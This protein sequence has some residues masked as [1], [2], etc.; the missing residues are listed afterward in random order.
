MST[1]R[2]TPKQRRSTAYHEA[3]HALLAHFFKLP[4]DYVTILPG[5]DTLGHLALRAHSRPRTTHWIK[6]LFLN[7]P[8][9]KLFDVF[10]RLTQRAQ[11]EKNVMCFFAGRIAQEKYQG[12]YARGGHSHDYAHID[13]QVSKFGGPPKAQAHWRRW[14]L[15][16]TKEIVD[17]HWNEVVAVAEALVERKHLTSDDVTKIIEA[18]RSA[19]RARPLDTRVK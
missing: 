6:A 1:I 12:T 16:W 2:T 4:F 18:Q 7:D 11:A 8:A 10:S 5:E 13:K 9:A 15:A 19:T 14:L 17:F 3:G